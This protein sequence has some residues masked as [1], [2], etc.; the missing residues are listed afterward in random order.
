MTTHK[1]LRD[2]AKSAPKKDADAASIHS[3]ECSICLMSIA[4]SIKDQCVT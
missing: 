1:R 2:L 3:S 4:V